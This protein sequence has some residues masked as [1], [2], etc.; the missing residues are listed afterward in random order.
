MAVIDGE[1]LVRH[2][3]GED[4]ALVEQPELGHQRANRRIIPR[5]RVEA[6]DE[7]EAVVGV[8]VA[9][10]VFREAD[11]IF[12]LLVGRDP[13]DEQEVDEVVVE[14]LV[15]RRAAAPRG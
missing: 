1:V 11:V 6:T 12:D 13:A 7:D 5:H 15:E 3:A 14:Q 2:R 10:V 9:L 4:E 8:H